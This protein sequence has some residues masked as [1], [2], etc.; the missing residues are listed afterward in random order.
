MRSL[1]EESNAMKERTKF[2]LEWERRCNRGE[3]HVN[4]A[5]LCREFETAPG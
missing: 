5:Q 2:A 4:V 1:E 3:G